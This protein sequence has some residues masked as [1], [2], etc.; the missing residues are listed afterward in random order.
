MKASTHSACKKYVCASERLKCIGSLDGFFLD[1]GHHQEQE[2]GG[3]WLHPIKLL[4]GFWLRFHD[5]TAENVNT[6]IIADG[7]ENAPEGNRFTYQ[8]GLGHTPVCITRAQLAPEGINGLIVTYMLHNAAREVRP[9]ELEFLAQTDLRPVWF[10]ETAGIV[11]GEFD[12]GEWLAAENV[13]LAKDCA[14]E[15]YTAIGANLSPAKVLHGER[16]GPQNTHHS[17]VGVSLYFE[18]TLGAGETRELNFYIAGS[19]TSRAECLSEYKLLTLGKDFRLEKEKR[20][21]KLLSKS[22]LTLPDAHFTE[23]FDW[24]KV[25]TDWLIQ[26]SGKYGRGL[27]A[28]IPEYPWWFGCDSFYALQGVLAMGDFTLCRDTLG[29]ILDYSRK[30]NGNGRIVHE[31]TTGGICANP[32]NTQETAHFLLTVYQYYQWTGDKGFVSRAF[33]YLQKC[34][35]WLSAQDTDGDLFPSG[36]GIIEIAGLHSEMIDSAVYTCEGYACFAKICHV[37]DKADTARLWEEKAKA[38][39]SA[40]NEKL[41]DDEAGLYCDTFTSYPEVMHNREAILEKTPPHMEAEIEA[42]MQKLLTQKEPLGDTESGWLINRNWVINTPME[43]GLA[44]HDKAERALATL[45]TSEFIGPWGMYLNGMYRNATMTISTGVMAVAQA[46][47]G[48]ADRALELLQKMFATFGMAT[49]GTL[50]EMSPDSG[51]FVQA[52][53]VYAALTPVVQ[54]FFGVTPQAFENRVLLSPCMPSVWPEATLA[55]VRVPGGALTLH[56]RRVDTLEHYTVEG[57]SA[58]PVV[59]RVPVDSAWVVN[60]VAYTAQSEE[61]FFPVRLK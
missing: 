19:Y 47:Y 51:C 57:A 54:Y 37:L 55:N 29:L 9:I 20:Y 12:T 60:G 1:F 27:T 21:E 40:I 44:P 15:W 2:M 42:L 3:V 22:R 23:V 45:H 61:Q 26:D 52:W 41:W 13:F 16:N 7:F 24:V 39:K 4:D 38:L 14:H 18:L 36:Y 6:W 46:R 53:T 10:S 50:S 43:A 11:D 8:S 17:G 58:M 31:V 32:G 35:T 33:P 48:Y 59:F 56:Y 30:V 5:L 34:V 28:G 49:P 25:N